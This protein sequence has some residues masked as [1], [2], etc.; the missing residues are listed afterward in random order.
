MA[1]LTSQSM[2]RRSAGARGGGVI[3]FFGEAI[4][5]LRKAVWPTHEEVA[6]LT[7]IVIIIAGII[8]FALGVLDFIFTQ[9][10]TRFL[11]T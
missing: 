7:I 2:I 1:R 4:G 6:R 11:F 5:E 8:G 10:L 3:R 9:T